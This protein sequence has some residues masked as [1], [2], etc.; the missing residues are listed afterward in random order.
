MRT[1]YRTVPSSRRAP[2]L[3][4]ELIQALL[5][6]PETARSIAIPRPEDGTAEGAA[7]AALAD[8]CTAAAGPLTTAAAMQHFAGTAHERVLVAALTKAHDH[9]VSPEQAEVHLR[10]GAQR[11]WLHAQRTGQTDAAGDVAA[12]AGGELTPEETERLRQLEMVRRALAGSGAPGG[13]A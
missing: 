3:V 1:P 5:L 4:R 10:A 13:T 2:S 12:E 11:Y 9:D 8:Y 7:L 6:Q